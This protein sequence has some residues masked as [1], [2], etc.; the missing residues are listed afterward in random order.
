MKF[1]IEF[2]P[3]KPVEKI[4]ALAKQA[5]EAAFKYCWITD[6]YNNRNVYS[7]LTTIARETRQIELGPGVTNPYLI[8]PAVTASAIASIDEISGGRAILGISAGDKTV[9]SSL[10]IEL[11]KPITTV[12][13]SVE[14]LRRLLNGERINFDGKI[15]KLKGAQLSFKPKRRVPIYLGA[16]GPEMLKLASNASDGVLINASHPS[17]LEFAISCIRNEAGKVGRKMEEIDIAA[18]TSFSVSDD[19]TKARNAAKPVVAF[20]V[21]SSP[22]KV[23]EKHGISDEEALNIRNAI[24]S[25]KFG[26]A[27][28]SI[29][30]KMLDSFC[31]CGTPSGC[32]EKISEILKAGVSQFVVG[33]PIGPVPS[34]SIEMIRREII[35]S[36]E[37]GAR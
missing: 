22:S 36:F 7:F 13:E 6:H 33:S 26:D 12:S 5:E 28:A 8:H 24:A 1:G 20:I 23:L 27:I 35:P 29:S 17:D 32:I 25:G 30:D 16:Q 21:A 15:F 4:A 14:I 37:Q 9:L 2:V 18:Y 19:E 34:E 11:N 3:Y 10:G 31:I